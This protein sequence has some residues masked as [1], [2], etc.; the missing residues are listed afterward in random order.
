MTPEPHD[1]CI[2]FKGRFGG[3]AL[4]FVSHK[5]RR[6]QNLRGVYWRVIEDGDVAV[7]DAITVLCRGP[8]PP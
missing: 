3:D 4:R 2:K 1:G 5:S 6:D 8:S 7:G